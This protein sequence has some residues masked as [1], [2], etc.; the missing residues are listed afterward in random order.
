MEPAIVTVIT[1]HYDCARYLHEAIS[2]ILNQT[3]R[4]FEMVVVDD[5]RPGDAWLETIPSDP[6][7]KLYRTSRNVGPYRIANRVIRMTSAPFIAFQDADDRSEPHRL[8]RLFE[9]VQRMRA[10][11][12]GSAARYIDSE[13]RLLYVK[14]FGRNANL[15]LRIGRRFVMLHPSTMIR[16]SSIERIGPFDGSARFAADIEFVVRAHQ[17]GLKLRNV[18]D[19]LYD[20]RR[21]PT[22]LTVAPATGH[23]S[24]VRESYT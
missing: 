5:S 7:L 11:V 22:S 15:H 10:D 13:G 23:G 17:L 18:R 3:F 19:V 4:E 9:A 6:R 1:P 14:R 2:S 21:H 8:K 12:V 20:Y 24:Q 16:R